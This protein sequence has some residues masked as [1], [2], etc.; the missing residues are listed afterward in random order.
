MTASFGSA[1]GATV[2]NWGSRA[3]KEYLRGNTLS[4]L[5]GADEMSPIQMLDK[6]GEM[7]GDTWKY[8][9]VAKLTGGVVGEGLLTGNEQPL[10]IYMDEVTV[11][12]VRNAQ[13]IDDWYISS[14]NTRI[15]LAESCRRNLTDW[16]AE[17]IRDDI[18]YA[19]TGTPINALQT[20][21]STVFPVTRA[22]VGR[23]ANRA[24][25]G[26][27][28]SNYNA[29]EAT[30]LANV[31]AV[32]DKMSIEVIRIARDMAATLGSATM[33]P[34]S[35]KTLNGAPSEGFVLLINPRQARDLEQDGNWKNQRY[36][37]TQIDSAGLYRGA[38]YKGSVQGVDV[39]SIPEIPNLTGVGA[40]GIDVGQAVLLGAQAATC[41]YRQKADFQVRKEDDYSNTYGIGVAEVR[42]EKRNVFNGENFA[43]L[44]VYTAAVSD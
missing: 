18:L 2:K 9:L 15:D 42:G 22:T 26:S 7:V 19:L 4:F 36:Y 23:T 39:F 44:H 5:M 11:R 33:R 43:V 41:V 31:D 29:T 12:L 16:L 40:S 37:K 3:F 20:A 32:N 24:L 10:N 27:A 17:T 25:Y 28:R 21:N 8:H 30:A 35:I 38:F 34:A 6:E 1:H 14:E 13:R